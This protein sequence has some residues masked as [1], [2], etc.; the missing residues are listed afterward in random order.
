M[1]LVIVTLILFRYCEKASME[2]LKTSLEYRECPS[3][4]CTFGYYLDNSEGESIFVCQVCDV[5]YCIAC[6]ISMHEGETCDAYKKRIKSVKE[7]D[8][9]T[10]AWIKRKA[11]P[12]PSCTVQI[13][14]RSGCDH[15]TCEFDFAPMRELSTTNAEHRSFL[16]L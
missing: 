7:H 15:M 11:K 5:K 2:A 10:E 8:K 16:S 4:T 3:A 14:K 6:E 1:R 12:C 9:A 13:Q